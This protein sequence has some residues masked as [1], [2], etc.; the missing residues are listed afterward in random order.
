MNEEVLGV[1][2]LQD[3]A[4]RHEE[5]MEQLDELEK[6]INSVLDEYLGKAEDTAN[7]AQK[8]LNT[9]VKE[10]AAA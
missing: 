7:E 8:A 10:T 1:D 5:V 9:L 2:Y 6:M 4:N 3:L